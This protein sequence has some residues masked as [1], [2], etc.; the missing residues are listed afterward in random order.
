MVSCRVESETV[1]EGGRHASAF[2][3]SM[4]GFLKHNYEVL[5]I[6]DLSIRPIRITAHY[7]DSHG[8]EWETI[9][10]LNYNIFLEQGDMRHIEIREVTK[11]R[12]AK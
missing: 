8:R 10:E 2:L 11:P 7:K 9:N 1:H 12:P 5:P 4:E 3:L 6:D